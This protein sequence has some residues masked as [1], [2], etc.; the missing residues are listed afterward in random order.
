VLVIGTQVPGMGPKDVEKTITWRLEKYVS[1]TPGV[2]HV[3][4]VSRSGLSVIY[5]WLTWGTNLD[6]AQ[7]LVQ[8]QVAFAMSSV[9]KSLGVVPP[10]VLQYD[11]T[12][13]PV[14]QIAV[15][16]GG[17]SGPQLY[18][19]AA[20]VIEPVIEGIAGVA[21]AAP[22]GGRERQINV[23][24][25]PVRASARGITSSDV[26][27]AV[28][29]ANALL[30]S[31]RLIAKSFDANV[32]TNAVAK[33]VSDIGTSLV[34]M[35]EGHPVFI[36]DVARVEDG[37][38]PD[39]QAVTVNGH[40]A[41]YLNVLRVPG[42]NVLSI[43]DAIHRA[44][45]SLTDLPPGMRI[46]PVFDQSTFVRATFSGLKR[47]ILQAFCLVAAV[48]LLFLQ[49]PRSLVIAAISVPICFAI[50]LIALSSTGQ[51]LNAFTLG[52]LTLAMGPLVDI[53]VVVIE[54][55][56]RERQSGKTA[57]RAALDGTSSVAAPALAATLCTLAV[58]MPV[59]L[60]SGLA[61]KLFVPLALTV[62]TGMT[63][64]YVVS[65]VVTPV[66]CRYFLSHAAP[67]RLAQAVERAVRSGA[68]AYAN[69]LER[70]L[71]YR[72]WV[73]GC[74]CL[75]IG[76]GAWFA[77]RLP[78]TF[79][80]EVDEGMECVYLRFSAGTSLGDANRQV[81]AMGALLKRELPGVDLVLSNVGAPGK[82]RSAMNSPNS[83]PHTGFIRLALVD[84]EARRETQRELADRARA[85]LVRHYPGVDFLQAPG[86]LV[87]SVFANGYLA[88]LVIELRGDDL[89]AL[90]A[91]SFAIADVAR[92]VPGLRDI[93]P[94]LET[95]YPEIHVDTD[96]VEA[97]FV[98]VSARDAAQ[99]TLE[100]TLGNI[101][102]PGVWV[103]GAN[104]QSY[105]VVTS[106]DGV[107][108]E[109]RNALAALP[110]RAT[111]TQGA[112][113]LGSYAQ[114]T[115]NI[116]PIAIERDQ[117]GRVATIFFQTEGRDLGG[118][119]SDLERELRQDPRTRD[120]P[121][122]F[123]GQVALMRNTFAGLG[124]AV[125][126]AVMIVFMIMAA[127]FRS[128]RLPVV[129]LLAIPVSV[130]GIV[131][132]L[133]AAGQGFSITA[134]M[135]IL[136]VI[137]IAVSNGI[138]LVDHANRRFQSGVDATAAVLDA[139]RRRVIPIMMT[140]LAT[141]IGLLPT[142][143]GLDRAA[144]ANRPLALAV[145]GGLG[146]ST[147]LSLFLVPVMFVLLAK[148]EEPDL[149]SSGVHRE[150]LLNAT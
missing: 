54:A 51:S 50:I 99:A 60:L 40:D 76:A 122:S 69:T 123:V 147:L 125:G 23:V 31:G 96:R 97:G 86:G 18:D 22:D 1:A 61:K 141:I 5:V 62:G 109:D 144:A 21:S 82:A 118:V 44:L 17:L 139:A 140:S 13:A 91:G 113:S 127:Q 128:L 149:E 135:G 132:A 80:P 58:L 78:S 100:G 30:P 134:L 33:Q 49:S 103:D 116:G 121:F 115:R 68:E 126:L 88:P 20:N 26:A 74:A 137:G 110:V 131:L 7:T 150:P 45:K 12:N 42:G 56:H 63:A 19:Y 28:T 73:I 3:Q 10:F 4:S 104:G 119:A 2:D 142:A 35:S 112:V 101:N 94:N 75:L 114:I 25:D 34:K 136:M 102:T 66:A 130:I 46:E 133:M 72:V 111:T 79:F 71:G 85:L 138:L 57:Y 59:V 146:S 107:Q 87:A 145:V 143:L 93:Y 29:H 98:G 14:I 70:V 24:V 41:V 38:A 9:P 84:P 120:L 81:L 92:R 32:Y 27:T 64:G 47:E 6:S 43:V 65:M 15:Y 67:G 148:R 108:V 124:V 90:S 106:Y 55:V 95:D 8:Q 53:S 83:G 77:T 48:I 52:G 16:G 39:T 105:Y 117:L 37:G 36:R 11:P 129:M 89:K